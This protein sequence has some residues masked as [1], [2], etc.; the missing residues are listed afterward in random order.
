MLT[1][2]QVAQEQLF[3]FFQCLIFQCIHIQKTKIQKVFMNIEFLKSY[4]A[5]TNR[6]NLKKYRL[7]IWVTKESITD[8]I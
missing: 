6:I 1:V 5:T 7:L 4:N 2:G 8:F 3:N